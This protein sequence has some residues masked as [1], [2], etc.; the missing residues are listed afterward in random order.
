MGGVVAIEALTGRIEWVSNY[1][2][3]RLDPQGSNALIRHLANRAPRVIVDDTTVFI[4]PRDSLALLAIR[5]SDGAI[6]WQHALSDCSV[7]YGSTGDGLIFVGD[8]ITNVS[9][10]DGSIRWRWHPTTATTFIVC[11]LVN[12][13]RV[14][15]STNDGLLALGAQNGKQLAFMP[16]AQLGLKNP[17]S[18]FLAAGNQLVAVSDE[19]LVVLGKGPSANKPTTLTDPATLSLPVSG[20]PTLP[21]AAP[22][23]AHWQLPAAGQAAVFTHSGITCLDL[24][25]RL[26]RLSADGRQV[27]WSSDQTSELQ[28]LIVNDGVLL[29][30]HERYLIARDPSTG[31]M[32][33]SQAVEANDCGFSLDAEERK[34]RAS[35]R[36]LIDADSG[37]VL[38]Q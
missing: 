17:V 32:V 7:L 10:S 11:G 4:A 19:Q 15:I 13:E 9:R 18:N 1:S 12:D 20:L 30:V 28:E 22:I 25:D 37:L 16:W 27:V 34:Y 8:G 33:W 14:L 29:A 26:V 2:R 38:I 6:R 23:A 5:R 24:G 3:A 31:R 21:F 36:A 35:E